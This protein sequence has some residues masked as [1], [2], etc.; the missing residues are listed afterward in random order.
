MM[1]VRLAW[2]YEEAALAA[3]QAAKAWERKEWQLRCA[4]RLRLRL[5]RELF[6]QDDI[7]MYGS[8]PCAPPEPR[9]LRPVFDEIASGEES[10]DSDTEPN[11]A[12]AAAADAA[13]AGGDEAAAELGCAGGLPETATEF[14][15]DETA[16]EARPG[17]ASRRPKSGLAPTTS[18]GAASAHS[19]PRTRPA[20]PA[21]ARRT[22]AAISKRMQAVEA[23]NTLELPSSPIPL[24]RTPMECLQPPEHTSSMGS[25]SDFPWG[26]PAATDRTDAACRPSGRGAKRRTADA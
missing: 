2:D 15:A 18:S 20:D 10:A 26:G 7:E 21:A 14:I 6:S 9:L 8:D 25:A 1:A 3:D 19:T 13:A 17:N 12:D 16:V 5:F 4:A 22:S 11:T 24:P 23:E